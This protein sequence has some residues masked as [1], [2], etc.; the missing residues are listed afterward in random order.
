[1]DPTYDERPR[2]EV[3]RSFEDLLVRGVLVG[4]R[5]EGRGGSLP[6]GA[7]PVLQALARRFGSLTLTEVEITIS[8]SQGAAA[9][10]ELGGWRLA[11]SPAEIDVRI[12]PGVAVGAG[13]PGD[14]VVDAT[15][16]PSG[17]DV[18]VHSTIVHFLVRSA[19]GDG[20]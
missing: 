1:M 11:A 18:V 2:A 15:W 9:E 19:V 8:L 20:A 12:M 14:A 3:E 17:D 5:A 7:G 16:S 6:E 10:D 13:A 4:T